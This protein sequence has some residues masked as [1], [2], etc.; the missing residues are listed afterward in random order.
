MGAALGK[1][2]HRRVAGAVE[3]Q[4]A[5]DVERAGLHLGAR[6][7]DRLQ[8]G[9]AG[10]LHVVA[11]HAVPQAARHQRRVPELPVPGDGRA[12]HQVLQLVLRHLSETEDSV[13]RLT[14]ELT[15]VDL[16]ERGQLP[17]REVAAAPGPIRNSRSRKIRL[18][19]LHRLSQ[20]LFVVRALRSRASVGAPS[21]PRRL[22]RGRVVAVARMGP[23]AA[24]PG[25][26]AAPCGSI[27]AQAVE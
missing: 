22:R 24:A 20:P 4:H 13:H 18:D 16:R 19:L 1:D 11:G 8:A 10:L 15:D 6:Q 5:D 7:H 9:G 17:G 12:D 25:R 2:A 23:I 3:R 21:H 27:T 14:G 26:R